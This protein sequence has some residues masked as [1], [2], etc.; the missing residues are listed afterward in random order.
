MIVESNNLKYNKWLPINS[1]LGKGIEGTYEGH[2]TIEGSLFHLYMCQ[3]VVPTWD[4]GGLLEFEHGT[5]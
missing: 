3:N 2:N 4:T 1:I 5:W